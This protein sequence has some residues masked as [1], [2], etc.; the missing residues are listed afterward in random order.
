M[1]TTDELIEATVNHDGTGTVIIE[2]T[3]HEFTTANEAAARAKTVEQ[4]STHATQQGKAL[5]AVMHDAQG[6]WPVK[7]HPD[8]TVEPD[9]PTPPAKSEKPAA[10]R[11]RVDSPVTHVASADTTVI[12]ET[13]VATEPA[14][15]EE[16]TT[17]APEPPAT[18]ETTPEPKE[19]GM[20]PIQGAD[21]AQSTAQAPASPTTATTKTKQ[22]NPFVSTQ[23]TVPA[24][25][26]ESRQSFL[27]QEQVEEPATRGWRGTM[28]RLGIRLAPVRT[29]ASNAL[30]FKL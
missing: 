29:N 17:T 26:R 5:R 30:T 27:T 8:G 1:S 15:S 2:G 28:T 11:R 22:L 23:D 12:E 19:P 7:V 10:R 24:P 3:T 20:E 6:S 13:S 14:M 16:A 25:R 18:A 9:T 21:T 4:V